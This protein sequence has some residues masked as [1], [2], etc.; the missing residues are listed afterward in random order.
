MKKIF[1]ALISSIA[2][3]QPPV[4]P[5]TGEPVG[6]PRGEDHGEYNVMNSWELGYRF[7]TV[8]GNFDMYRSVVNY[9]NGVRLLSSSLSVQS[10]DGHG[11]WFDYLLLNTQGIGGDPYE[12]AIL[13]IEKNGLYRY[14]MTWRL[15]DYYNPALTIANG[16]H[17]KDTSRIMQDHDF[18][19]FPTGKYKLFLGYSHNVENGPSL[20]T[21]QLFDQRSDT[22]PLFADI[23]RQMNEYRLGGEA[24]FWGFRLNVLRGWVDYREDTPTNILFSTEPGLNGINTLTAY[25]STQPYHGTSPYW[26][27]GLFRE[28]KKFWALNGRFSY[29][30][31][32]RDFIDNEMSAGT[33]PAG[34]P[35]TRQILVIGDASRPALAT[36]LNVTFFPASFITITNQTTFNNI[37]TEGNALFSEIDN[38]VAITPFVP[39][40]LLGVRTAANGTDV[41]MRP[42][43]K[44]SVHAGY[45][46]SD[47]RIQVLDG[48]QNA[49]LPAPAPPANIP[50]TQYNHLN[51]GVLGFR[52]RPLQGLT[53]LADGEI[54]RAD[55]PYTPISERDYTVFRAKVDYKRKS[56]HL[57]AYVKTDYNTNSVSLTSFASR[58]RS[59]GADASWTPNAWFGIDASFAK[60]H[61]Y[62]LGGMNFFISGQP[63]QFNSLYLSNIYSGTLAAHFGLRGRA[64]LYVGY[65]QSQDVG[66]GRSTPDGLPPGTGL[67]NPLDPFLAVQTFPLRYL[68]P[69]ARL[70]IRLRGRLRWN[71][72]YQYYGYNEQFTSFQDFRANTG[73]TSLLWSF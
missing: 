24:D 73:F 36:N 62:T 64:D 20:T 70:S 59:Y 45:H 61:L 52:Y 12:S 63:T 11:K 42:H 40:T 66:D 38:G 33:T 16:E 15:S 46:Y 32:Q 37:R 5:T 21:I 35:A 47:R 13:R 68:S 28:G 29:I 22:F 7:D 53:I 34:A 69:E 18:T 19:L 4:A 49:G 31:G 14:D 67:T 71:V 8:G 27:V 51:S 56:Y 30:A 65:S 41:E 2:F 48:Q 54:G 55:Q 3:A 44:F 17:F 1:L 57:D 23:R 26:R 50:I 43:K 60:L 10:R 39:F 58:G 9:T 25:N 72:G 6:N